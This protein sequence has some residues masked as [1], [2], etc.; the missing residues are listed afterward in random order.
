MT[1]TFPAKKDIII[2]SA[3]YSQ[4]IGNLSLCVAQGLRIVF[5]D[6]S[7]IIFRL[8]GTGSAGAT[9][10]LYIDSYEKDPAKIYG[11]AQV[12]PECD[13]AQCGCPYTC[14]YGSMGDEV[15]THAS[16]VCYVVRGNSP[17]KASPS[18]RTGRPGIWT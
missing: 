7:R 17:Q 15:F 18:A 11:D 12:R 13:R 14:H 8:S 3:P 16:K 4:Y 6:G 1:S 10:R 5:S 2:C 9:V